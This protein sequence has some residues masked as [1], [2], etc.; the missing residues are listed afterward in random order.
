MQSSR[1]LY[2]MNTGVSN[3][4]KQ[5]K[6][7]ALAAALALPFIAA[8]LPQGNIQLSGEALIEAREVNAE[9]QQTK[10]G[11]VAILAYNGGPLVVSGY[12]AP[13]YVDLDGVEGFGKQ[14][15]LL[16][17]HDRK[18]IVGT[19][20]AKRVGSTIEATGRLVGKS[21]DRQEIEELAADG[22]AWQASVGM[23][24]RKIEPVPAGKTATVNG[25]SVTGPC[26]IART[27]R[28]AELTLAT[29]GADADTQVHLSV[30]AELE[31]DEG[32]GEGGGS[33]GSSGGSGQSL[34]S[35]SKIRQERERREK[36]EATGLQYINA[37]GDIDVIDKAINAAIVDGTSVQEFEL[38]LL[39][40]N[41]RVNGAIRTGGNRGE[42]TGKAL[43][44]AVEASLMLSLGSSSSELEKQF[45]EQTLNAMDRDERLKHGLSMKD[46]LLFSCEQN[47]QRNTSRRDVEA[48]LHGA[49]P[50]IRASGM[51]TFNLSGILSNV[52]NKSL[53]AA[54]ETVENVWRQISAIGSVTDFKARS[55]YSLTGDMTYEKVAP[56]GE[57]KHATMGEQPYSNQADTYGRMFS[58]DRRDIINDDL[59]ALQQVPRRL[60][61][62]AALKL[63]DVFWAEFLDNA[64]F[65]SAGNNNYKTGAGTVLGIDSLSQAEQTFLDQT[66]FDGKPLAI[67]PAILLTATSNKANAEV[68]MN[69]TQLLGGGQTT[70]TPI[71]NPHANKL[72]PLASAYIGTLATQ[73]EW[74]V[75]ADP[76]DMAVIEVVF[77]NGRQEPVVEQAQA[78]FNQLGVQM[79]GYH[80]WG[81]AKQEPKGGVKMKGAA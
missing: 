65:F 23:R 74:Y 78:D 71:N 61:R 37:G 18:R 26:Y 66:D 79:R 28:M 48:M 69:S 27:S 31:G 59:S 41:N 3:K 34:D 67:M 42:L 6:R 40:K 24:P 72:R 64:S 7:L 9:G 21:A 56:G 33:G 10:P 36:I 52:A 55:S 77:L 25:Q 20:E 54:F 29:I 60:G 38:T 8:E 49:L 13:I 39:R 35:I 47:G 12:N 58:I 44:H 22:F 57:I 76:M 46:V 30:A 80:D 45:G 19:V 17:D 2:Q 68:L 53:R 43:E 51:S 5:A 11:S 4:T 62:G 14:I 15:P 16:R 1:G 75:L 73:V 81:I 32:E 63:N 70:K 50:A